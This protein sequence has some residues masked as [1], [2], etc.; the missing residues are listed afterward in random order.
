MIRPK[1]DDRVG[2]VHL[3]ESEDSDRPE[4]GLYLVATPIGNL[5]DM[6]ERGKNILSAADLIACEDT[7]VTGKLRQAWSLKAPLMAYHEHNA[8]Q[9]RPKLIER[10]RKGQIVALVSDAGTPLVSDPG[11]KLVQDC[12]KAAIPFTALPGASAPMVALLLSGLPS[13]RFFFEGFLPHKNGA[14]RNRLE[15]LKSVPSTLIFFEGPGRVAASL[16]DMCA[17]LGDRPAAVARELT[18][19]FEDVRRGFLSELASYYQESGQLRGEIVVVVGAPQ[20]TEASA[21]ELDDALIKAMADN[22][23]KDAAAVVAE[24]YGSPKKKVYQRALSLKKR[25]FV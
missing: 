18:K 23:L 16:A 3:Y 22:S 5:G 14:R 12:I 9:M 2:E 7:R 24:A 25:A 13:D 19:K 17:V 8:A 4:A 10:V 11:Y 15:R 20:Q 21:E 6:T 1:C